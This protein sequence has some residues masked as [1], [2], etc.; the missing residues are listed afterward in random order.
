MKL[1]VAIDRIKLDEAVALANELDGIADVIEF[2]TSLVKDYGFYAIAEEKIKLRRSLL[3]LDTKTNDEGFYEFKQGYATG[4]DI[5]TVMGYA[6]RSTLDNVYEVSQRKRKKVLIDLM[7]LGKGDIARIACYPDAIFNLHNS[8]DEKDNIELTAQV[9][10]FKNRFPE[11][12]NIAV[13]GK[14]N[15]N[16]A[17]ALSEQ[18]LTNI[19]IVGSKIIQDHDPVKMAKKFQEVLHD[20]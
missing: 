15:L 1:Q 14:I 9:A 16:V 5:L 7:G 2:G 10:N 8:Y 4:A 12:A 17:Q 11:I 13:A 6:S 20:G 3:L 19:V 18:G